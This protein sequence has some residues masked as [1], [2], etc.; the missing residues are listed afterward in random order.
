MP[1]DEMSIKHE[2]QRLEHELKKAEKH[3]D[4]PR[5]NTIRAYIKQRTDTLTRLKEARG[6]RLRPPQ[7]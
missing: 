1:N 6:L 7:G 3:G 4:A 2:L 5:A